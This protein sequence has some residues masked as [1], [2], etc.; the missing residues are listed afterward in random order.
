MIAASVSMPD[1]ILC[2]IP[3]GI[4]QS[5]LQQH[6][7]IIGST[8]HGAHQLITNSSDFARAWRKRRTW[9]VLLLHV[10]CSHA[11]LSHCKFL[12]FGCAWTIVWHV[13]CCHIQYCLH[14]KTLSAAL[15]HSPRVIIM[16]NNDDY[17]F[18]SSV[19]F[20]CVSK[21]DNWSVTENRRSE[22][23]RT[24]NVVYTVQL[25]GTEKWP[26]IPEN[27]RQTELVHSSVKG[28]LQCST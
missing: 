24:N 17:C 22:Q 5:N 10:P 16:P 27:E 2:A 9:T 1:H 15:F 13:P 12:C 26:H 25:R 28:H 20:R 7:R 21:L 8:A 4:T 3:S 14:K 18:Y 6:Y 11:I 19:W 23:E